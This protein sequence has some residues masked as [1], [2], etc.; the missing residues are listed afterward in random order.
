MAGDVVWT[1]TTYILMAYI[2][3]MHNKI[4]NFKFPCRNTSEFSS[5]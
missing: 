1:H 2:L 4:V 3:L 5:D